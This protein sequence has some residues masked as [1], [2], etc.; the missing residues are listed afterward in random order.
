MHSNRPN[1]FI[2]RKPLQTGGRAVFLERVVEALNRPPRS[3]VDHSPSPAELPP[4]RDES[5]I[6]QVPAD[7]T[8]QTLVT[9]W[10]QKARE[11]SMTVLRSA[12]GPAAVHQALEQCLANHKVARCVLNARELQDALELGEFLAAR[13]IAAL[14]WGTEKCAA[15]AFEFDA[16]IT[17][18]RCAMA[19]SGSLVV[20]SDDSFGRSSTL[21]VPV[22]IVLL[23]VS[24]IL[25]DMLDALQFAFDQTAG[26]PGGDGRLPSNIV[27]ITGPSKTADIEMNM[28]TG[29]HGPK[30]LYVILLEDL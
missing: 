30:Y 10:E 21:V 18:C 29:V 12:P 27:I 8:R 23:P 14:P 24:R 11:N 22:H 6:R 20:W 1:P 26:R 2:H 5:L 16:S 3:P 7:A 17:D 13:K 4:P 9:R 19:D 28:V 15:E 25:P